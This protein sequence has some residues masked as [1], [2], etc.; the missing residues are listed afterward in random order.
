MH[1]RHFELQRLIK[2][3]VS[4]ANSNGPHEPMAVGVQ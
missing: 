2:G 4:C 3:E 1:E